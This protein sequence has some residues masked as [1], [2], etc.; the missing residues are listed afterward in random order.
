MPPVGQ[1]QAMG[2]TFQGASVWITGGGGG[3]GKAMAL[4][5]AR[6]GARVAVSGRREAELATAV[7]EIEDLG[8]T[9]LAVPC[10]VT[11][12]EAVERA[13]A[14]VVRSFGGLDVAVANAGF[15]VG[16]R[17]ERLTAAE[18]RRQ[19]DVN[20]VGVAVT[21]RHAI[22]HLRASR[23]RLALMGSAAALAL[24]PGFAP[25]QASK[26]AV[27]ALGRTLAMELERDGVS[28]TTLQPGF[29]ATD[30]TRVD[31]E[32]RL[33]LSRKD[34]RPA[35]LIWEA[36]PAASVMVDAI[37]RRRVE[38]TFTGHGRLG[39]FLGRHAPWIFQLLGPR[40]AARSAHGRSAT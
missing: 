14:E 24:F 27:L 2:R 40:L 5:F 30:I 18:W 9:A 23:G 38:F 19:L 33:D 17:V 36:G 11:D 26:A 39:V 8:R 32:G 28:V 20:V 25:Y 10:D 31:N 7:R 15:S 35:A 3:L 34:Q 37:H 1:E 13:V 4:E 12:E 16:G 22:P 6:R 29:V 21:A